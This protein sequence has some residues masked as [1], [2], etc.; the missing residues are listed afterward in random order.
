MA[1]G[2]YLDAH[3]AGWLVMPEAINWE[4]FVAISFY[5]YGTD[6]K[7]SI[8][9]DL[10]DDGNELWRFIIEDNFKGWKELV[11]PFSQ[12]VMRGDWQP[13]FANKNDVLDFPI[14]SFQFE[15]LP[16]SKGTI[17]ID[18]VSLIFKEHE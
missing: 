17:Y 9:F 15:P 13:E 11:C 18:Q 4:E 3:N 1:K 10:K 7:A 6:S 16:T 12:F 5:M 14:R 8:A 2:F